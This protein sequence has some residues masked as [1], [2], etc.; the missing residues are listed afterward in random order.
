MDRHAVHAERKA[1][2]DLG[3]RSRGALAAGQAVGDD[4]N[5]VAAI[6]LAVREVDD[7]AKN[8]AHGRANS[9]QDFERL[10]RRRHAQYQFPPTMAAAAPPGRT[11][12]ASWQQ[13]ASAPGMGNLL[14]KNSIPIKGFDG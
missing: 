5:L 12:A 3:K 9:M 7:V 10:F 2:R 8:T 1:R 6:H 14:R 11:G 4:S 13:T